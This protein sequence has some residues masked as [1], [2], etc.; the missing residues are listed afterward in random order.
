FVRAVP[1][2]QRRESPGY[3]PGLVP[4]RHQM[5][6]VTEGRLVT[7]PVDERGGATGPVREVAN[8]QPESPSWEGDSRHIVYQTPHGLRRAGAEGSP[9][10]AIALEL[11]WRPS[12]P[13]ARVV[14]HAGQLLDLT[15]DGLRGE[16]DIVIEN[17]VI[18]SIG[19][20]RDELHVGA[21]VDAPEE[22]VMP[23]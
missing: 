4:R 23:G 2:A 20:H 3:R 7:V 16:S 10:E 22:Y 21:V 15:S 14:V 5:A 11:M 8:D 17:G 13:P 9:P 1:P 19:G 12:A 6:F 18:R